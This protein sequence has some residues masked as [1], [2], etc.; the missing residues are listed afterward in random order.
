MRERTTPMA[1]LD[2]GSR[3][4]IRLG[5]A[6]IMDY[7]YSVLKINEHLNVRPC[8]YAFVEWG[9]EDTGESHLLYDS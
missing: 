6:D 5:L 7:G 3:E 1:V 2:V 8:G 9:L 4:W